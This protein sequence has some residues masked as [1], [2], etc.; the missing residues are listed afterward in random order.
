MAVSR[1][2][3]PKVAAPRAANTPIMVEAGRKAAHTRKWRAAV[4]KSHRTWRWA[5]TMT[6]VLIKRSAERRAWRV[7]DFH[8]GTGYESAGIVDLVLARRDFSPRSRGDLLEF[9]LVQVKG[10]SA[11][12]PTLEEIARLRRAATHHRA[13]AVVLS[14]WTKGSMPT[15]YVP[16]TRAPKTRRDAWVRIDD[17]GAF[18]S[19]PRTFVTST[20][21]NFSDSFRVGLRRRE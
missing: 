9:V 19:S 13:C 17:V 2:R 16:C 7:L 5:I 6:R 21:A 8:S 3:T 18:F 1:A 11:A 10:G 20:R 15:L 12:W 4:A 14:V